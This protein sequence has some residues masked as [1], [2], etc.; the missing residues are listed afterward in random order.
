MR[1]GSLQATF[2]AF[3]LITLLGA[4]AAHAADVAGTWKLK[5]ETRAGTGTPTLVL[6]QDGEKLSG[7]YTGRFGESPV[8]GTIKGNALVFS[9]T[10]SG[11]MGSAEVTYTG[12]V[13]GADVS[14]TMTM[15]AMAGGNFTGHKE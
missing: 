7:T 2:R 8:T 6:V 14:G 3:V 11:P 13:D 5:V 9:F 10:G 4:G 1:F 15:G 12:V